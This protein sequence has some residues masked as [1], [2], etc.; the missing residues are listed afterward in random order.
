MHR[1]A[2]WIPLL[3]VVVVIISGLIFLII[4][5]RYGHSLPCDYLDSVNITGGSLQSDSSI[6]FNNIKY[7]SDQHFDVNYILRNGSKTHINV[8]ATYRR[9]CLC[10]MR[11][12]VRLCCANGVFYNNQQFKCE[13]HAAELAKHFV[14]DVLDR[15][16]STESW[17]LDDHFAFIY[18]KPCHGMFIADDGYDITY[19]NC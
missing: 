9:G 12:C 11:P 10:N 4:N 17:V 3:F 14:H 6:I 15:D 8:N 19:V 13:R 1:H 5:L 16:N 18:D 7:P 2:K